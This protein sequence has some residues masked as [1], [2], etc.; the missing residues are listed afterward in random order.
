MSNHDQVKQMIKSF[1]PFAKERY[2]FDRPAKIVLNRDAQNSSK[3]LGKTA[4]YDPQNSS[5]TVYTHG[6]H[7]KDIMRSISHE[8]VHH[9]QNCRGDL[10]NIAGEQG[11]GYAQKN[12]HLREMEREA[13]EQ[14]NLCFRD[15]E[16]GIKANNEPGTIYE[17]RDKS[18]HNLFER[19]GYK[20]PVDEAFEGDARSESDAALVDKIAELMASDPE[21]KILQPFVEKFVR[22]SRSGGSVESSLEAALP[23]WVAGRHIAA[24]MQKV[25]GGQMEEA[26][27]DWYSDEHETLAD[28][29]YA[30]SQAAE[31]SL[32]GADVTIV[33]GGLAG[34][35]G[36]VIEMTTST[37][38]EPAV[39][40][41]LRK[42]ADKQVMGKA[43]DEVIALVSDV[44]VD[45]GIQG[46]DSVEPEDD[47]NWVGHR[48]HYQESAGDRRNKKLF[49]R[50]MKGFGYKI[51]RITE[52]KVKVKWDFE[53]TD[54]EGMDPGQ[55]AREAGIPEVVEI[56]E[57]LK[58]EAE[59]PEHLEE[60]I[61]DW[62][63]DEYGFTHYGW[64]PVP[65]TPVDEA[66][67]G[68]E[69][70]HDIFNMPEP[71][72]AQS[73]GNPK[74]DALRQIVA[75]SQAAKVD[76]VMVDGYTASAIVQVLDALR[77]EIKEK[78]LASPV[79]IMAKLAFSQMKE[80]KLKNRPVLKEASDAIEAFADAFWN[81]VEN[82]PF[83]S[84]ESDGALVLDYRGVVGAVIYEDEQGAYIDI[85]GLSGQVRDPVEAA[86][87]IDQMVSGGGKS[88]STN[89]GDPSK[90]DPLYEA[91]RRVFK[92]NPS[93]IEVAKKIGVKKLV[94]EM[95]KRDFV[96]QAWEKAGATSRHVG[97]DEAG[98]IESFNNW[99][100]SN[101][102]R[103]SEWEPAQSYRGGRVL[104]FHRMDKGKRV[105]K[106][107][108]VQADM[109]VDDSEM[110]AILPESAGND[111]DDDVI[112]K[113]TAIFP[114]A[115]V[116]ED[117]L[118]GYEILI[119]PQSLAKLEVDPA[120]QA[121]V[122]DAFGDTWEMTEDGIVV[123]GEPMQESAEA[124]IAVGD[125]VVDLRNNQEYEVQVVT[126]K[127]AGGGVVAVPLSGG[128]PVEIRMKFLQKKSD[129]PVQV[130][131]EKEKGDIAMNEQIAAKVKELLEGKKI[132]K[133]QV[134][135]IA[136]KVAAKLAEGK[137][138]RDDKEDE[139]D[140]E[141]IEEGCGAIEP[142]ANVTLKVKADV[143]GDEPGDAPGDGLEPMNEMGGGVS[144]E[145]FA[146]KH[147]LT[148]ETDN[149]GQKIIYIDAN[150]AF[151]LSQRNAGDEIKAAGWDVQ[152]TNDGGG[153]VIYTGEYEG[154]GAPMQES[155]GTSAQE[156]ADQY[157]LDLQT[158]NDGQL[159]IY[160]DSDQAQQVDF[161]P[162][163]EEW[164]VQG[165]DGGMFIIYTGEQAGAGLQ[166]KTKKDLADRKPADT[167]ADRLKAEGK[168]PPWLK[169]D[170]DEEA[171]DESDDDDKKDD[172]K[173]KV[174]EGYREPGSLFDPYG[175]EDELGGE[176]GGEEDEL[177][178]YKDLLAALE[179]DGPVGGEE[180]PADIQAQMDAEFGGEEEEEDPFADPLREWW[181]IRNKRRTERFMSWAKKK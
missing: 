168:Q 137:Y 96:N 151:S 100:A 156:F 111:A 150:Q 159:V 176:Y 1:Y 28:K 89:A 11:Q 163:T 167:P 169:K 42:D 61:S 149:D 5:V 51:P 144:V 2:G 103:E 104:A 79:H 48:A 83:G 129:E 146:A 27:D 88:H 38:G 101:P 67:E 80:N 161:G 30:D 85:D 15:W 114:D 59:D 178:Q 25:Q 106:Y 17:K 90:G 157:G 68:G 143:D 13:Y 122:S 75:Q 65:D 136:Q 133:E 35:Q 49:E 173:D 3:P 154:G 6:R 165:L 66:N 91:L 56:P 63:S 92:K 153:F 107:Y 21:F 142:E 31:S 123:G 20:S 7:P 134:S 117:G 64:E 10:S 43:G 116:H 46:D 164:D 97:D 139:D 179:S 162:G 113:A 76:G 9:T 55:A 140:K 147:D 81:N 93:L 16:D 158:D 170:G 105:G 102:Q 50:M 73:T 124:E 132:K 72:A 181:D 177:S 37:Q 8:L 45:K 119:D 125:T 53:D 130:M 148:V 19:F 141:E 71:E 33:A 174:E 58:A 128:E 41:Y 69:G 24:I 23:D 78:Y 127:T 180:A 14:G 152:N 29:K 155:S 98:A 110:D 44:E 120:M 135:I 47:Y 57:H 4:Y 166:E 94:E 112:T 22:Y 26:N 74:E 52:G 34:A 138:K 86:K 108:D 60:L 39:V 131:K 18:V 95:S 126:A 62:L 87:A 82:M 32:Q 99:R 118:G 172:D 175:D 40:V 160:M 84:E 12:D 121:A 115:E 70:V 54:L 109:Y 171:S 145:E 36:E 77:P